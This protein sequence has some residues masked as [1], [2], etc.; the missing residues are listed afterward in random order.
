MI[1]RQVRL[2][3]GGFTLVELLVYLMIAVVVLAGIYQLLIGQ[4]RLWMKQ[5]ELQDVRTSLRA[6]GSLLAFEL[7]QASAASG[8]LYAIASDSVALRSVQA[9]GFV[10]GEHGNQPRYGLWGTSGEF[11]TTPLDSALV[12]AAGNVGSGDDAWRV[13]AQT[14][15]WDPA[16]GGVTACAWGDTAVGR[17]KGTLD[18]AGPDPSGR[19]RPDLVVEVAGNAD[20]VYIG[21]PYRAFRPVT[22]G[23]FREDDRWWLGRRIAVGPY[24]I[25][26][27]PLR[28]PA[29][30]GLFFTYY[31]QFGNPTTDPT[32]V[33]VVDIILRGESLGKVPRANQ[34]PDFQQDTLTL[35]VSLR[36]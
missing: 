9:L 6:A 7:R 11:F 28:S 32:L 1:D 14:N 35:R 2:G 20:G 22:Y 24:E 5:R 27:G 26:T 36:G 10:C 33:Q 31:D 19:G 18:S 23:I 15:V 8:D 30:S 3:K 16:G 12:F 17:G 13:V 4:N 25:L 29:D 21:A 34:A